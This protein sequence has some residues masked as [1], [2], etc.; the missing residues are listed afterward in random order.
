MSQNQLVSFPN[1]ENKAS[2]KYNKPHC[3][4]PTSDITWIMQQ[5]KA[6]QT[7]WHEC[8]TSDPFGSRWEK[9]STNLTET[10]FR[11]ARKILYA[12]GLF[13]FKRDTCIH[14]SRKTAG[15]LV[16][17]LHG[18]RRIKD[19][20]MN[21]ETEIISDIN[22]PTSDTNTA[23][24][25]INTP[26]SDTNTA[27]SDTNTAISDTNTAISDTKSTVEI[28]ETPDLSSVSEPLSSISLSSQ[29]LLKEVPEEEIPTKDQLL[30]KAGRL[31][32]KHKEKIAER[33][34]KVY[35]KASRAAS[36]YTQTFEEII[37]QM[38]VDR[39]NWRIDPK[40]LKFVCN[41]DEF[42]R[43][44]FLSGFKVTWSS[45]GMSATRTF[46]KTLHGLLVNHFIEEDFKLQ[47]Q[48]FLQDISQPQEK[49]VAFN[50]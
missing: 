25:D 44:R 39:Y 49:Q 21:E 1:R 33:L 6:V 2:V 22:T 14:D 27:I 17:N 37:S 41:L 36:G 12:A 15:W 45:Q 24:S 19:F 31:W 3:I 28:V 10:A 48:S 26:I 16:I 38:F 46:D 13:E 42:Q 47:I 30:E 18:A 7:L 4:I 8:W 5:V 34:I 40:R 32:G 29:E 23:I 9:L 43:N 35:E 50:S 11:L 20:W